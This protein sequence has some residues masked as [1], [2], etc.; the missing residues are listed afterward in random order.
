MAETQSQ[1]TTQSLRECRRSFR[2]RRKKKPLSQKI[3]QLELSFKKSV[4]PGI[5]KKLEMKI[6]WKG[7]P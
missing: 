6:N 3:L 1:S 5:K 7:V 4:P 2:L